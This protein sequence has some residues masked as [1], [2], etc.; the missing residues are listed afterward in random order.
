[1]TPDQVVTLEAAGGQWGPFQILAAA[2]AAKHHYWGLQIEPISSR[3]VR[4][5]PRAHVEQPRNASTYWR[6]L[7]ERH[8][9]D[10][11]ES[12]APKC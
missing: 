11:A 5:Y 9:H 6:G 7:G 3:K 4:G 10:L 1:M 8:V 12:L 2:T